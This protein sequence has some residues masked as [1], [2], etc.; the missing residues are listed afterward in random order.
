MLDIVLTV[1]LIAG[2]GCKELPPITP[3]VEASLP[4]VCMAGAQTEAAKWIN[5]HPAYRLER[6]A[7]RPHRAVANI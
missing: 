6:M 5:E 2:G 7:C 3:E 1:C 4:F